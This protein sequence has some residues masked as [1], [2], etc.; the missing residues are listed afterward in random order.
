METHEVKDVISSK[1]LKLFLDIMRKIGYQFCYSY[2][3]P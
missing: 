2:M 1:I 3:K